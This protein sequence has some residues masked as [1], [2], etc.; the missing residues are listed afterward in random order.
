[1]IGEHAPCRGSACSA[2]R[3]AP[4]NGTPPGSR[5]ARSGDRLQS[6]P[7]SHASRRHAIGAGP[8]GAS[9]KNGFFPS[10][11]SATELRAFLGL[12]ENAADGPVCFPFRGRR[13]P[14]SETLPASC[15]SIFRTQPAHRIS[16]LRRAR[17]PTAASLLILMGGRAANAVLHPWP[18]MAAMGSPRKRTIAIVASSDTAA[19]TPASRAAAPGRVHLYGHARCASAG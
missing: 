5:R 19:P 2:W 3:S 13:P 14:P 18:A 12:R 9:T 16:G 11:A 4:S 1:M 8:E 7:R 15:G 17:L 6:A 10:R